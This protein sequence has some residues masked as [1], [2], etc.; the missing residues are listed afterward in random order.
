MTNERDNHP[1]KR[2]GHEL[3][4]DERIPAAILRLLAT[5]PYTL[6][7]QFDPS[8]VNT[9]TLG[10]S[11]FLDVDSPDGL[12]QMTTQASLEPHISTFK[13]AWWREGKFGNTGSYQIDYRR[14]SGHYAIASHVNETPLSP[15]DQ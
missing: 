6:H 10:E 8:K 4:V 11:W 14:S 9:E 7:F 2:A 3:N 1:D 5:S 15:F 12:P 13:V